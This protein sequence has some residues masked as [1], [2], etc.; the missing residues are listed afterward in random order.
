M[1]NDLD[2]LVQQP[3]LTSDRL[4]DRPLNSLKRRVTEHLYPKLTSVPASRSS[5]FFV[6]VLQTF[7][8]AIVFCSYDASL[9]VK[10]Y[11]IVN[12]YQ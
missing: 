2:Q 12:K 8:V 3:T 9:G 7:F 5:L 6:C 1:F 10:K 11:Y 4:G